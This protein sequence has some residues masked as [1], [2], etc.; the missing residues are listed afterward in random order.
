MTEL[1]AVGIFALACGIWVLIQ[2]RAEKEGCRSGVGCGAC[3]GG[4]CSKGGASAD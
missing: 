2:R 4:K 3:G 1:V